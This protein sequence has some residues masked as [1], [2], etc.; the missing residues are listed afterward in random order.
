MTKHLEY[1]TAKERYK[2]VCRKR[3]KENQVFSSLNLFIVRILNDLDHRLSLASIGK[4]KST[5]YYAI[6][7]VDKN[8][9][10]MLLFY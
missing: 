2:T 9:S 8:K 10:I 5:R 3:R 4:T 1:K 7:S 6:N